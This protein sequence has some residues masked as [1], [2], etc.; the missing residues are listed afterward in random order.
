ML[1]DKN[2]NKVFAVIIAISLWAYVLGDINPTTSITIKDVPISYINE[3]TLEDSGKI[4]L[5]ASQ[6]TVNITISGSRTEVTK[7][8][9]SDFSVT[10]DVEAL[11][12][13]SNVVRLDVKE[14]DSVEIT[15]ISTDKIDITVDELVTVN[16]KVQVTTGKKVDDDKEPYIVDIEQDTI[17]VAGAKSL[18]KQVDVVNALIDESKLEDS[19]KTLTAKLEPVDSAGKTVKGVKLSKNNISV[20]VIMHHKKT[21]DLEIPVIDAESDE[22]ERNISLPDKIVIKGADDVLDTI[23]S[24]KC[25]SIDLGQYKESTNILVEPILP[26][27]VQ[28]STEYSS[29]YAKLTVK[30]LK[31]V[32]LKVPESSIK[33]LNTSDD[34]QYE[35]DAEDLTISVAG[36]ENDLSGLDISNFTITADVKSLEKG[37]HKVNVSVESSKKFSLIKLSTEEVEITIR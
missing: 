24:I 34:L 36:K 7:V 1:K 26:D 35:I 23:D 16:K 8:K 10:A 14:P 21:V 29:V 27:G 5:S 15:N 2:F 3:E 37:T 31:K 12:I 9:Q 11:S 17:E 32:T 18:V 30:E 19:E 28:V 13:G 20:T 22:F 25:K 4:V 33:L 6:D